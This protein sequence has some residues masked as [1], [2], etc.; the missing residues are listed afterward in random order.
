VLALWL[1]LGARP[2]LS[3]LVSCV[4]FA[5]FAAVSSYLAWIGQSSCGC[6][7]RISVNPIYA[8]ALDGIVL[9]G[10]AFG[11]PDLKPLWDSHGRILLRAAWASLG[12][13]AGLALIF[14]LF[15]GL[16][17]WNFTSLP[18]ALAY[19]RGARKLALIDYADHRIPMSYVGF[20]V[21]K[22]ARQFCKLASD[23]SPTMPQT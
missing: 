1:C 15:L 21:C 22:P 16:V 2:I 10:L 5:A 17:Y 18:E 11:R 13:F 6:F 3:W 8:L 7:G 20:R 12:A 23:P 19:V 14:G 9:T 4:T